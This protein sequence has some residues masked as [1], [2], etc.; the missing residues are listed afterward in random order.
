MARLTEFLPYVTPYV[1]GC[2]EPMALHHI[3][4]ACIDFC[5]ST[6]VWKE[7]TFGTSV[8]ANTNQYYV[9]NPLNSSVSAIERA[10]FNGVEIPVSNDFMSPQVAYQIANPL[11]C[12]GAPRQLIYDKATNNAI[13][14]PTP[15]ES[16]T[17]ALSLHL[18][19][20]PSRTADTVPDFV[21]KEYAV[22]ISHG[23]LASLMRVPNEPYT[24]SDNGYYD[25]A[26][27]AAKHTAKIQANK[28]FTSSRLS[29]AMTP[30]A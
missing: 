22:E 27:A 7:P 25:R 17:A 24:S 21:F 3:R 16:A 26:F 9:E 14:S 5:A 30:F 4:I 15:D 29:V 13:L 8:I 18:V 12:L 20:A 28:R 19:L 1:L 11:A 10:W 6:G 2:S 23:A